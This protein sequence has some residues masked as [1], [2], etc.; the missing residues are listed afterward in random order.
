MSQ[1]KLPRGESMSVNGYNTNLA[2]CKA[3]APV[4]EPGDVFCWIGIVLSVTMR[5]VLPEAVR[6]CHGEV[7]T[8]S[9]TGL[10]L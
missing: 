1:I 8:G 9:D 5:E 7:N 3:L 6:Y 10:N 2:I 4:W